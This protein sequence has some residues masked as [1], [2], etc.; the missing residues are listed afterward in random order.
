MF[1]LGKPQFKQEFP[2]CDV[3][4]PEGINLIFIYSIHIAFV[5]HSYSIISPV[6]GLD[7]FLFF[8]HIENVIIPTDFHS[9]IFQR[10]RSTNQT[11][12]WWWHSPTWF[13]WEVEPSGS[14]APSGAAASWFQR[15]D[16]REDAGDEGAAG[17]C[18]MI[19]GW[20]DGD[21]NIPLGPRVV[22]I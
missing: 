1:F 21:D 11:I 10:G 7:H 12:C 2:A 17:S 16:R 20:E 15:Q 8:P 22:N 3:W 13:R 6:G 14:R 9:M 4:L 5:F 18:G 19:G